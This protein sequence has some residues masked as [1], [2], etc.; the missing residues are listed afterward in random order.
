MIFLNTIE[1]PFCLENIRKGAFICKYCRREIDPDLIPFYR[2]ILEANPELRK[3]TES[4]KQKLKAEVDLFYK[5]HLSEENRK[6][7]LKLQEDEELSKQ[8]LEIA[9][10]RR[11]KN[12]VFKKSKKYIYFIKPFSIIS[13][14]SLLI[15][16]TII[17]NLQSYKEYM[18]I[19]RGGK[20]INLD[21]FVID[22]LKVLNKN[23]FGVE[24]NLVL[25]SSRTYDHCIVKI[26]PQSYS[27]ECWG[28][29]YKD[30]KNKDL[31]VGFNF[32]HCKENIQKIQ[33]VSI[34]VILEP[35][36]DGSAYFVTKQYLPS[37]KKVLPFDCN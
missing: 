18:F 20:I 23:N 30:S 26:K 16:F 29:S 12:E 4:I 24:E 27:S 31:S 10:I 13:G 35:I 33:S 22:N 8:R 21:K 6:A 17:Q 14:V 3:N 2:A 15:F 34:S 36:N 28:T 9:K 5:K 11:K 1:C 19:A 37:Y 7:L 32:V 25:Q